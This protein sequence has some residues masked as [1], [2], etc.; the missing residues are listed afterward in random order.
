[1]IVETQSGLVPIEI[2]A[3]ATPRPDMAREINA[4]RRDFG[5]RATNGYVIHPGGGS[6]FP[7]V[8][9]HLPCHSRRF[10]SPG[11]PVG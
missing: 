5:D 7:W 6:C 3:S 2:K 10:D 1:M 11:C 8:E 9:V 4:F